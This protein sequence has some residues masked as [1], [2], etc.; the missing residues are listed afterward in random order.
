[1]ASVLDL[2]NVLELVDYTFNNGPFSEKEFVH[3]GHQAV[4]HILPGFCDE[5]EV[6]GLP[7]LLK[8]SLGKVPTICDQ[9]TKQSF[10]QFRHRFR[11]SVLA[12][13]I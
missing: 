1:M 6:E 8:Q 13:V 3:Q 9:L 2:R 12:G 7:K 4:L 11:S 5:L 10:A